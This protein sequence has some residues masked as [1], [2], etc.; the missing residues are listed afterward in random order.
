MICSNCGE[1][2][3]KSDNIE[4]SEFP[5][6][7][8]QCKKCLSEKRKISRQKDK[9]KNEK[10]PINV[11]NFAQNDE[12]LENE[13]SENEILENEN[14]MNFNISTSFMKEMASTLIRQIFEVAGSRNE[15]W[16]IS[17]VE[18]DSIASPL[19]NL[20]SKSSLY[21]KLM[22]NAD[23][24]ALLTAIGITIVPRAIGVM[25]QMKEREEIDNVN[26]NGESD[27]KSNTETEKVYGSNQQ[28]D[29]KSKNQSIFEQFGKTVNY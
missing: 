13:N 4:E 14:S 27:N 5:K 6:K 26:E 18:S 29:I 25:T 12:N 7:G 22:E 17:K 3:L 19:I 2:K 1:D 11:L 20:V 9:N 21:S 24:V 8:K 15:I 10:K 23:I 28:N 16:K